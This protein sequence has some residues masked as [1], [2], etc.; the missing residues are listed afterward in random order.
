MGFGT[1]IGQAIFMMT[2]IIVTVSLIL[3]TQ[4]QMRQLHTHVNDINNDI[5][6]NMHT[7]VNILSAEYNQQKTNM[8]IRLLNS[9]STTLNPNFF[10]VYIGSQRIP[11]DTYFWTMCFQSNTSTRCGEIGFGQYA[12][13]TTHLIGL[14]H[15][16]NNN[17][18]DSSGNNN[19]AI[20]SQ[21]ID[22]YNVKAK[23]QH[24]CRLNSSTYIDT[25]ISI[26][27]FINNTISFW[28][29]PEQNNGN[30]MSICTQ[31]TCEQDGDIT[32]NVSNG[33]I[34]YQIKNEFNIT[35]HNT[36]QTFNWHHIGITQQNDTI[37]VYINGEEI[38]VQTIESP[39]DELQNTIVFGNGIQSII[40]EI[41]IWNT[42]L[43]STQIKILYQKGLEI[44]NPNL[45]DSNEFLE[46]NINIEIDEPQT[47]TVVTDNGI[48][49]RTTT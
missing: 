29:F 3:M 36:L 16:N 32:L 7:Q 26:S 13:E 4:S 1:L 34:S 42:A 40:D 43:S 37:R 8:N 27:D 19:H 9:G 35:S 24:G 25:T 39:I 48:I 14:Y 12:W 46:T 10:D 6:F 17:S 21:H 44:T 31:T 22:C 45:W 33:I 2:F 15:L 11:R 20:F 41:A 30:I 5:L 23:F 18:N 38:G 47:I 28:F 49:L